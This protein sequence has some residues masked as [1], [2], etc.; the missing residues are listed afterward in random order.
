MV[1]E[2]NTNNAT[3]R[4]MN[5]RAHIEHT[6]LQPKAT[7]EQVEQWAQEAE[8]MNFRGVCVSPYWLK[9][10]V[11]LAE[12]KDYKVVTVVDFPLGQS[13]PIS[14]VESIKKA[15]DQ[16]A[17]G[18]DVVINY[19]AAIAEDWGLLS[20]EMDAVVH[21]A[22]M[23]NLEIKLILESS[24]YSTNTLKEVVRIAEQAEPD[25]IKTNTGFFNNVVSKAQVQ[26]IRRFLTKDIPLKASG[27]IRSK[28]E[29]KEYIEMGVDLIGASSAAKW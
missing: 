12:G 11:Q 13:H 15:A 22:R 1:V 20:S 21:T 23:K 24:A 2:R 17:F 27:G 9:R 29:A 10:S 28:E 3:G 16:G 19:Q 18:V 4:N 25:Y 26:M 5:W 6:L 7:Q 8:E 14:K